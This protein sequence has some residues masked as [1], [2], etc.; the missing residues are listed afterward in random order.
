[1]GEVYRAHDANSGPVSGG[2]GREL[3]FMRDNQ[4]VVVN[5]DGQGL[6]P[7]PS[8]STHYNIVLNWFEELRRKR[9][10]R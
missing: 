2:A 6:S 8:A 5:L 10:T 4:F 7:Q 9:L 3:F 1:V